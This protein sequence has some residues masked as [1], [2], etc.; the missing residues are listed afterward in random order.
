MDPTTGELSIPMAAGILV[1]AAIGALALMAL[2]FK[3]NV[4]F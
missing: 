4:H 1:L 3:G 2:L